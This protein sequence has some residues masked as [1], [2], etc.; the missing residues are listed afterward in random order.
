LGSAWSAEEGNKA[1]D[2]D[3]GITI[4]PGSGPQGQWQDGLA[5]GSLSVT[6]NDTINGTATGCLYAWIDWDGNGTFADPG[7]R[8]IDA[9][10]SGSGT[11]SFTI[12]D[13]T[14]AAPPGP[15]TPL[16]TYAIRVRLYE[17]CS[18]GPTGQGFGGEMEDFSQQFTPTAV[19]LHSIHATSQNTLWLAVLLVIVTLL[20]GSLL[21]WQNG[22]FSTLKN[23]K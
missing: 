9:V 6:V 20:A 18:S 15:S 10:E 13:G 2:G 11:Y 17:A 5:G 7:E 12:P 21:L 19:T 4:G 8:V 22:R 14:F 16:T 1:D 23:G 3:D